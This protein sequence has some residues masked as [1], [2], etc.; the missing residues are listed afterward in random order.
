MKFNKI[1]A[2]EY[3][4]QIRISLSKGNK[5]QAKFF[6]KRLKALLK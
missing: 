6:E 5:S 4:K 1:I 2:I 3:K